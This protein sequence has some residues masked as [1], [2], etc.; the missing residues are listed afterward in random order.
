MLRMLLYKVC[1]DLSIH[2]FIFSIRKIQMG[3][4]TYKKSWEKDYPWL[5]AVQDDIFAACCKQCCKKFKIDWSRVSQLRSHAKT[6]KKPL[7]LNQVKAEILQA[8]HCTQQ[9]YS[10]ASVSSDNQRFRLMFPD[11]EN[12]NKIFNSVWH[13]AILKTKAHLRC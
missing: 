13:C 3:K 5:Q 7:G 12:Q 4:T 8:L 2:F 11:S 1:F 10:F 9:N 6:H